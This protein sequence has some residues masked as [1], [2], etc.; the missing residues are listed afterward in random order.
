M[1]PTVLPLSFPR[2]IIMLS[3]NLILGF[4]WH[5]LIVFCQNFCMHFSFPLCGILFCLTFFYI[6]HINVPLQSSVLVAAW[7]RVRRTWPSRLGE[8]RI[9]DSKIWSWVPRDS[10]SRM[11]ALARTSSSCKRQT[12]PLVRDNA[13]RQQTRK[14]LTV[15]KIWSWAPDGGLKPRQTGRLTISHNIILTLTLTC[16]IGISME[17]FNWNKYKLETFHLPTSIRE[18]EP[19]TAV[20]NLPN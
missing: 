13:S 9:W 14:C 18:P 16:S 1:Q 10:Y 20:L 4:Q 17:I 12:S 6:A 19:K 2:S 7:R 8:H 5:F 15:I 3:T 11:I